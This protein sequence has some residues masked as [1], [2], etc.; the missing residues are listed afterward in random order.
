M[1]E[2]EIL[3]EALL[4]AQQFM[5]RPDLAQYLLARLGWDDELV[6]PEHGFIAK[7][8]IQLIHFLSPFLNDVLL[9][10]S[11]TVCNLNLS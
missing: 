2:Q 7:L 11:G 9:G 3:H 5:R 8:L 6:D 4:Q 1:L 10:G